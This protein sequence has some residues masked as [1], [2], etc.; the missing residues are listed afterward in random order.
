MAEVPIHPP[1]PSRVAE[2][3]AAGLAPRLASSGLFGAVLV[4]A[5]FQARCLPELWRRLS[6]LVRA[7]LEVWSRGD[8]QRALLLCQELASD[9]ARAVALLL[10][11]VALFVSLGLWLLQG[12]V[13]VWP[14]RTRRG[15]RPPRT[16][17][18]PRALFSLGL[19]L[20]LGLS[21]MDSIWLVRSQLATLLTSWWTRL[22]LLSLGLLLIDAAMA[23]ERFFRA[24]WLTR[25]EQREE[26]REAYGAPELRTARAEAQQAAR[27]VEQA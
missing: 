15:F 20:L 11:A 7:P 25:R 3:R 10:A 22:A 21:L 24:L 17:L 18:V 6:A 5:M 13:V 12:P 19:V 2:A 9:V 8:T 23:R 16:S 27:G 1:T 26:W 4:L 14:R